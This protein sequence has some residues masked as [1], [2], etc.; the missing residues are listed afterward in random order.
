MLT[1]S[2]SKDG[3]LQIDGGPKPV[4]VF[5]AKPLPGGV[6]IISVPIKDNTE[7]EVISWPGEYD[8]AGITI[9]GIGHD[10]GEKVSYMVEVDSV[11]F[12]L[13]VSPLHDW[14]EE[15]I[16]DL[17]DIH[18]LVL[19]ADDPKKCQ[20]LLDELD[21]R[22]L[23]IV[24]A[25]DGTVHADVLKACGAQDQESV[26]EHKIKGSLPVEGREVVVFGK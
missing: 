16:E 15:E 9:R 1:L 12:A 10:E 4:T 25:E 13:P 6:S 18:V 7:Q 2:L 24:P 3:F 26:K 23:V 17:G 19:P 5:P 21:P 8:V 14:K 22:I 11:R 20:K